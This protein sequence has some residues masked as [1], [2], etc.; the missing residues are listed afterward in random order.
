MTIAR[1]VQVIKYGREHAKE[2][3]SMA[4]DGKGWMSYYIDI[5]YSFH[6][7]NM[8]SNEYLNERFWELS[9][10][11]KEKVGEKY[12]AAGIVR[13]SWQKRFKEDKAIYAKYGNA[14]YELGCRR[15]RIRNKVYTKHYN[16]GENLF[17]E[18]DVQICRQHYLQGTIS[19]GRN[20][21]LAKHCFIDYSGTVILGTV[22][23]C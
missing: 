16:A 14:K 3:A 21:L 23:K 8:W 13:D 20:V 5:L 9:K 11:N 10:E 17:V 12:I 7:Y 2:I 1:I 18:N 15:R 22:G 6:K 19:I 4:H